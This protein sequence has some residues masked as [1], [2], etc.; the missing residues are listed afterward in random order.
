MSVSV[1]LIIAGAVVVLAIACGLVVRAQDGRR[2]AGGH[3]RV[4]TQDL[5]GLPLAPRATLV[6]FS[7]ELCA[8]CPQVRRLLGQIADK[9]DEVA[10]IDIDLTNRTDLAVRYHVLQT[11]T[12][13]LVDAFG[14]VLSR[15]GGVPHRDAIDD[16]LAS[17]LTLDPQEQR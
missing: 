6:Q 14:T 1:A 13:F 4:R 15:W 12:T 10:H 8:R 17:V 2:R 5:A 11:P 3:L 9:H 7:T 16:A